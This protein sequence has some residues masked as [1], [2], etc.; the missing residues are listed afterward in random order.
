MTQV[1]DIADGEFPRLED[2]HDLPQGGRVGAGKY[3]HSGPITE[4]LRAIAPHRLQYPP[5]TR[6]QR[7]GE[8]TSHG[9][10]ALWSDVF[11]HS[12]GDYG[13]ELSRDIAIVI[14]DEFNLLAKTQPL[15]TLP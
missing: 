10:I 13:I 11:E 3:A 1:F 15:A 2:V 5:P 8:N 14:F 12:H 4:V 6:S 7:L 9:L